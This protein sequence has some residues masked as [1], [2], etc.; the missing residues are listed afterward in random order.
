MVPVG[1]EIGEKE[2]RRNTDVVWQPLNFAWNRE[3]KRERDKERKRKK[4]IYV[5]NACNSA[6][7]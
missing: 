4:D 2:K 5:S 1:E 7:G 6:R 3:R